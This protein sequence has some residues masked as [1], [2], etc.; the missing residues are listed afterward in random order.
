MARIKALAEYL[1]KLT[2]LGQE[3]SKGF[4]PNDKGHIMKFL[5]RFRRR[6]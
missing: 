1:L 3:A 2:E 4:D 5:T 6:S